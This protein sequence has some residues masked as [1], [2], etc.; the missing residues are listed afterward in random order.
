MSCACRME[1]VKLR[2]SSGIA[3][4]TGIALCLA[5][6]L[7]IA[8]YMGPGLSP[9]NHHCVFPVHALSAPSRVT[10][11]KGT[12]LMVLANMSWSLWIVKQ[13]RSIHTYLATCSSECNS[14]I[15]VLFIQVYAGCSARG[16]SEQGACNIVT[17]CFQ[18]GAV[19]RR[20]GGGREGLLQVEAPA[21]HQLARHHLY[22]NNSCLLSLIFYY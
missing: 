20:C 13:V 21:W 22:C 2:S 14:Y 16:V 8:L 5:G 6:V 15:I 12:F 11:I 7:V 17:V 1:V 18:H 9:I 19:I 10:W 4:F 3:K